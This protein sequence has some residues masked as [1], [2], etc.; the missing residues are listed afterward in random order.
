MHKFLSFF[1]LISI[2]VLGPPVAWLLD[3]GRAAGH[4]FLSVL[5]W[6]FPSSDWLRPDRLPAIVASAEVGRDQVHNFEIR[7]VARLAARK[8]RQSDGLGV[9]L[10]FAA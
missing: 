9:G 10:A 5:A 7:R 6:A 1:S 2:A 4:A 8:G 3:V